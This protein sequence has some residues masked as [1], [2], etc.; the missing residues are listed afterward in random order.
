[1]RGRESSQ[2]L[3]PG[4]KS[5]KPAAKRPRPEVDAK[6]F[7]HGESACRPALACCGAQGLARPRCAAYSLFHSLPALLSGGLGGA[8]IQYVGRCDGSG[9]SAAA[10]AKLQPLGFDSPC[11]PQTVSDSDTTHF[12]SSAGWPDDT[13]RMEFILFLQPEP[14]PDRAAIRQRAGERRTICQDPDYPLMW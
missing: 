12:R 2:A 4:S 3:P 5:F 9:Q 8:L 1:M 7:P 13:T 6:K 14:S 11:L 10:G